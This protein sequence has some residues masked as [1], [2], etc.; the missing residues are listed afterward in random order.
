MNPPVPAP[1]PLHL[2]LLHHPASRERSRNGRRSGFKRP[3][4]PG[5]PSP[6][7]STLGKASGGGWPGQARPAVL[8]HAGEPATARTLQPRPEVEGK[9]GSAPG[10]RLPRGAPYHL[11]GPRPRLPRRGATR[12]PPQ[13]PR[14]ASPPGPTTGSSRLRGPRH[15]SGPPGPAGA[16]GT[17]ANGGGGSGKGPGKEPRGGEP[18]PYLDGQAKR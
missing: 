15:L 3:C 10:R 17:A 14:R 9:H 18:R 5:D 8:S 11:A 4:P 6:L 7:P 16:L 13:E 1:S 12:E 2:L